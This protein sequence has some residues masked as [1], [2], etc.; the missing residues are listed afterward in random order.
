VERGADVG[1][2]NS[3]GDTASDMARMQGKIDVANWLD[4]VSRG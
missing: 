3:S 4:W 2:K 1:L